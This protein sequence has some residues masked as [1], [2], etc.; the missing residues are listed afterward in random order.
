MVIDSDSPPTN[1]TADFEDFFKTY[2]E[3][4]NEF[5]YRKKI[6]EAYSRGEHFITVLFEDVLNYNPSLAN[7]L[8]NQPEKALQEAI[9]AFKNILRIDSG[10]MFNPDEDYFVRIITQNNSCEVKLRSIRSKHIDHLIYIRGIVIRAGRVTPEITVGAFECPL[11]GTVMQVPQIPGKLTQP[12]DCG[13]PNCQNKKDFMIRTEDSE[14]IDYQKI[15]VQ[16]PPEELKSGA[17]PQTLPVILLHDLVDSVRPGER[18]KIM[19][20]LQSYPTED[21]RGK[22]ITLFKTQ[23][24]SNSV[25]GM[26]QEEE[27]SDLTQQDIDEIR[28]L[29]REPE[30]QKKIARSVARTIMGMEHLKLAA[31][32]SLFG[33]IEKQKKDG[34]RIRGDI[35][36]L[37]LGD[38]G[39]GKSQILQNCAQIATRSI[40]TSGKGASAAGLTAAVVRE[41]DLSGLQL[42]AGALVLASGGTA[43]TTGDS[44]FILENGQIMSFAELFK[45]F[46]NEQTKII[47][48]M[49]KILGLDEKTLKIRPFPIKQ[50]FKKPADK[51]IYKITTRMGRDIKLTEDN[52]VLISRNSRF[53]W[54]PTSNLTIS[55]FIAV[56][57]LLSIEGFDNFNEKFAYIAGLI[58]SDGHIRYSSKHGSV[59]FY[60]SNIELIEVYKEILESLN[61]NFSVNIRTP[62]TNSNKCYKSTMN[63]YVVINYSKEFA[64]KLIDFGIPAGNKS[65]IYA[66]SEKIMKYSD[67]SIKI[68]LRG[69][70]DGDGCIRNKPYSIY[71]SSGI[72]KNTL[73]FQLLLERVGIFSKVTKNTREWNCEINSVNECIKFRDLIGSNH[74]TKKK[75]LNELDLTE[76]KDRIDILPNHQDYFIELKSKYHGKLGGEHYK[77]IWNYCKDGVNPS[78]THLTRINSDLHDEYIAKYLES[79]ILWDKIVNIELE[80]AKYVYDFSMDGTNNF[81]ANNIIMHNCIDEFDKMKEADR[82]AI[83][84][85]M[86]QQSY[87][88][89][90]IFSFANNSN[91]KIGEFVDELFEKYPQYRI[92]GKNCEILGTEALNYQVLTTNFKEIFPIKVHRVSRH[93]APE[94]FIKITYSNKETVIVTP[95]HPIFVF[96][97]KKIQT[98]NAIEIK[99]GMEIPGTENNVSLIRRSIINVEKIRNTGEYQSDW[100]YDVTIEPTENFIAHGLVLHNTVSIAKAGIV[101]T[102]QSK[103]S[104][105]AA[106]NPKM[107]RYD[108]YKTPVEN[109]NLSPPILSRFDLI[110]VVRDKPDK[111]TDDRIAEYILSNHMEGFDET[112]IEAENPVPG[113][114]INQTAGNTQNA[115]PFIPI[116]LL[117]KYIRYARNTCHPKITKEAAQKIKEFYVT[118]RN[119]QPG[120]AQA[121]PIVARNLEGIIRL[122]EAYA[123]MSLSDFVLKAHVD[124][125]LVLVQRSLKEVGYDESTGTYDVDRVAADKSSS[126]RA[127]INKILDKIKELEDQDPKLNVAFE[128]ILAPLVSD[129]IDKNF[130]EEAIKEFLK[131]GT[132]Y[133]PKPKEYKIS[134][135]YKKGRKGRQPKDEAEL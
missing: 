85:A 16:E 100:V 98:I 8:K 135:T 119:S 89:S 38:P 77:Y 80:E 6:S 84:E 17:V 22:L 69:V 32:L 34:S 42:E 63:N 123:K 4:P 19:G 103:T 15:T 102:L 106:A 117:K 115:N 111:I 43:C 132:I 87:H 67:N 36:V 56:P 91:V 95:D 128:D 13:N 7:Y 70:F 37:F 72:R 61:I 52:D 114:E 86:E 55:D 83:H 71:L 79:D 131:D 5:K 31:A 108:P 78:R 94:E 62:E 51:K 14:F 24:M 74:P 60:N 121:I 82:V 46:E 66:L 113:S 64:E 130:L 23:L 39:T 112:F 65:K 27:D 133:E 41:S 109:I 96:N 45:D 127:K 35:H 88:P 92:N 126:K 104:I 47:H 21:G 73:L 44:K 105:I 99:I 20:V 76:S 116:E 54:I 49:F 58:A 81:I 12:R 28:A 68:F 18:V 122:C 110:F 59:E 75:R 118:M 50:A 40:Y 107:G 25:E 134:P 57:K 101:A 3:V 33:G 120:E 90:F 29:A 93:T 11:C 2:E 53:D 48:P 125:V 129:G 30:I 26:S 9:D 97:Q 10:G 124:D 1:P